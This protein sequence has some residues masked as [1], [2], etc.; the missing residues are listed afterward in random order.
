[1]CRASLLKTYNKTLEEGFFPMIV[2]D[3]PNTKV[4]DHALCDDFLGYYVYIG[5]S[6]RGHGHLCIKDTF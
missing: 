5:T 4:K 3:A 1:M 6:D 2:V